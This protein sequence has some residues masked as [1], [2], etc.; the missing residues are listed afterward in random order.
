MR[1]LITGHPGSGKSI[2]ARYLKDQHPDLTIIEYYESDLIEK[3]DNFIVVI[4][5]QKFLR[6][7]IEF[8]KSYKC[9]RLAHDVFQVECGS[10]IQQF[11][12][13]DLEQ[14]FV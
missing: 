9:T 13:L 1:I 7:P 5:H 3:T 11:A 8:D 6:T 2:F 10:T 12:F 4:Q 14:Y